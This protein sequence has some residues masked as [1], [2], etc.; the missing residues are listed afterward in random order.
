[1]IRRFLKPQALKKMFFFFESERQR[2]PFNGSF[3][4]VS[5]SAN[6]ASFQVPAVEECFNV[7]DP[8]TSGISRS[9]AEALIAEDPELQKS[10]CGL[11]A[12]LRVRASLGSGREN[13]V[14]AVVSP[15]PCR[16]APGSCF[17]NDSEF[18]LKNGLR[19][20]P[21]ET[22]SEFPLK[23]GLRAGKA[24]STSSEFEEGMVSLRP[25]QNSRAASPGRDRTAHATAGESDEIIGSSRLSELEFPPLNSS[26]CVAA[27]ACARLPAVPGLSATASSSAF[28]PASLAVVAHARSTPMHVA[29]NSW[30][31][32]VRVQGPTGTKR[33]K[34]GVSGRRFASCLRGGGRG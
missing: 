25:G 12:M 20:A 23:N 29:H 30:S 6:S 15:S 4:Q 11:E 3:S 31:D 26:W 13:G 27:V 8:G 32:T 2:P 22:D 10:I 17:A 28:P 34:G 9:C 33:V 18:P 21:F 16:Q 7:S 14:L 24:V 1:M 19:A 5:S